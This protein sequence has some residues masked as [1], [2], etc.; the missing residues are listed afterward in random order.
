MAQNLG[1]ESVAH[2]VLSEHGY[3]ANREEVWDCLGEVVAFWR[4]ERSEGDE[5][6]EEYEQVETDASQ[7]SVCLYDSVGPSWGLG[8]AAAASRSRRGVLRRYF[9]VRRCP[10][11]FTPRCTSIG[12]RV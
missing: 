1:V 4:S 12:G 9:L 11:P 5:H 2:D 7:V 3:C 8:F 10:P 6:S